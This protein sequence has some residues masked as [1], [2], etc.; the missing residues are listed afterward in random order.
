MK[1][2]Y[3]TLL[4]ILL[5]TILIPVIGM[6]NNVEAEIYDYT[7]S[8][9]YEVDYIEDDGSFSYIES[10]DDFDSAKALMKTNNDYVVRCSEGYSPTRIVAMNSGLVYSY[11]RGSS[12]TQ[13]IYQEWGDKKNDRI[14]TYV[15][16][17][18]EMTYVDTP[19]MSA[20]SAY[21][22]QGY[23][24]VVMNGF[25]GF[26]DIEYTDLVPSKFI[27]KGI[28]IYLG[29]SYATNSISPYRII[30]S[31][32]YYMINKNGNYY[33]LEFHYHYAYPNSSGYAEEYTIKI[34][35][36]KNYDF[37]SV[38]TKYFSDD[39]YNFYTNYKKNT[40]VG[41][42]YNY[43]QFL[44]IRTKSKISA[45]TMDAFLRYMRNDYSGSAI[46]NKGYAFVDNGDEYGFNAALLYALSCQESAYGTS[47][48]AVYRN[49]LFGWNAYDDSPNN[50]SYFSSVDV[51]I[52]EM[53]GRN[54]RRYADFSD[55]RFNGAYV[56][57]KGSGFNLKYASDP[58]WGMK[59]GAIYYNLDK[60][61]CNY[62]GKLTDYNTWPIGLIK[63]YGAGIY[64]D[65]ACTKQICT[66]DY[67]HRQVA[68]MVVLL[69]NE[70][71]SYKIQFNNPISNGQVITNTDGIIGYSWSKSIAYVK[72]SDIKVLNNAKVNEKEYSHEAITSLN[73]VNLTDSKLTLSGIGAITNLNFT[74][75]SRISHKIKLISFEDETKVIEID[76]GAFD[77]NGFSNNDGFDYKYSGFKAEIDL[78]NI[79]FS[80][81]Y[82]TLTT[83]LDDH[84]FTKTLRFADLDYRSLCSYDE[85]KTY[86]LTTNQNYAYR[87]ELD[88]QNGVVNYGDIV[89]ASKRDSMNQ[90]NSLVIN[91]D[92]TIDFSGYAMI[93]YLNY[94]TSLDGRYELLLIDTLTGKTVSI[95]LDNVAIS[96]TIKAQINS[97]YVIDYIGFDSII[98]LNELEDGDYTLLLKLTTTDSS[99]NY[100]DILEFNADDR[101]LPTSSD[102]VFTFHE[103][104]I[105]NRLMLKV[106][107]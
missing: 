5:T 105:R 8:K 17:R 50:A 51:A 90:F 94:A 71:N 66:A 34:D 65:E 72:A 54:L 103:G 13:N 77:S 67:D 47:D 19:Y 49:N 88:I 41:T 20:K 14:S 84:T 53:M 107:R 91:D 83:T 55:S 64:Y 4:S 38:G 74:D 82:M 58:Y 95:D 2:F 52:K 7:S 100:F 32:N 44:P 39:G 46:N 98:D 21:L 93:Y 102:N 25:D 70:G 45:S 87:I 26:A 60:F 80:S 63:T 101:I 35:N 24:E 22:G 97:K 28:S 81:Y 6:F 78:S 59:I 56:G 1:K 57:N 11:P 15:E 16:R 99:N 61:S 37:M 23:V 18:Y 68:N 85:T 42:C 79:D 75:P 27:D 30:V 29:G 9:L 106:S 73:Y 48:Y 62:N 43:Y 86:H 33:D 3:L 104:N 40:L 76:A 12:S 69:E 31:P 92:G 36:A 89:K 10:F 96:D